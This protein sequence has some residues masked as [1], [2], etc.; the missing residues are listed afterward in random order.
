MTVHDAPCPAADRFSCDPKAAWRPHPRVSRRTPKWPTSEEDVVRRSDY[1]GVLCSWRHPSTDFYGLRR[2]RDEDEGRLACFP[3]SASPVAGPGADARCRMAPRPPPRK[4]MRI[5]CGLR[6]DLALR[7]NPSGCPAN[8]GQSVCRAPPHAPS[9]AVL[10]SVRSAR[11][12]PLGRGFCRTRRCPCCDEASVSVARIFK[13]KM[14]RKPGK[15]RFLS[16]EIQKK[17]QFYTSAPLASPDYASQSFDCMRR[18]F[19]GGQPALLF[20][21]G[22]FEASGSPHFAN[23]PADWLRRGRR[24]RM[25]LYRPRRGLRADGLGSWRSPH[26]WKAIP[27]PERRSSRRWQF[28]AAADFRRRSATQPILWH[29]PWVETQ[30]LATIE[31][32]DA[33][34]GGVPGERASSGE[35]PPMR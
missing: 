10:R 2:T 31:R 26:L 8:A 14:D 35:K 29:R 25:A 23:V 21:W 33:T 15:N 6:I 22:S 13:E 17:F 19:R 27:I 18:L 11:F 5:D 12:A 4:T 24:G 7:P 34:R 30:T 3:A 16:G 32:R 28:F 1:P 9:R 20:F